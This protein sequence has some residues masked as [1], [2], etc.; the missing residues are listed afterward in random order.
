M[1]R[2]QTTQAPAP[3]IFHLA[4]PIITR[5]SFNDAGKITQHRDFWDVKVCVCSYLP[6]IA[7][8]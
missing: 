1:P 5:L 8:R 3:S 2:G 4:L 7:C 6:F